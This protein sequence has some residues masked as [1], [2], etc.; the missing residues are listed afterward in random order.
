MKSL[1]HKKKKKDIT[2][3]GFTKLNYCLSEKKITN[4]F[5]ALKEIDPFFLENKR[6]HNI[7][8]LTEKKNLFFL[9]YGNNKSFLL[10]YTVL[11]KMTLFLQGMNIEDL[12]H[13]MVGKSYIVTG[14]RKSAALLILWL[15][16]S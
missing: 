5:L 3:N 12:L 1:Y 10:L 2:E 15:L 7:I 6:T 8:N 14:V 9:S 11:F 13:S 16:L 4:S